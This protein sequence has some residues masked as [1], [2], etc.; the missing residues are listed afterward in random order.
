[1]KRILA[2]LVLTTAALAQN[3]CPVE[4]K[5]LMHDWM[6]Y[7]NN[8]DK[9]V[10]DTKF[11]VLPIDRFGD[12]AGIPRSLSID[13]KVKPGKDVRATLAPYDAPY[14]PNYK[15]RPLKVLFQDGTVWENTGDACTII[16]TMGQRQ[17]H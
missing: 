9:N 6:R 17:A 11:E 5:V 14:G 1:M 3:P 13:G 10:V 12:P 15:V 8:S 4:V 16:A 2:L 7:H